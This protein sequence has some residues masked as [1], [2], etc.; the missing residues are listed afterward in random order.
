M[1]P[2]ITAPAAAKYLGVNY[3]LVTR[4]INEKRLPVIRIPGRRSV[5]IEQA[6]L[7]RLIQSWKTVPV[8]VAQPKSDAI[9]APTSSSMPK[10]RSRRRGERGTWREALE[11]EP[12]SS[13]G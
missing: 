9:P 8:E 7:D 4:L 11:P 1:T 12:R 5:L 10:K 6:D 13:N 2:L 3:R